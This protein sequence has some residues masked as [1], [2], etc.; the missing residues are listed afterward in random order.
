MSATHFNSVDAFLGHKTSA[1][2]SKFLTGWKE[3]GKLYAWLHCLQLP[4]GLW[5]HNFPMLVVRED[6]ETGKVERHV[7][8]Q[9]LNCWETED[10]LLKQNFRDKD[11]KVR[12]AMPTRCPLCRFIEYIWQEVYAGRLKWTDPILRYDGADDP[13]EN[14]LLHAAGIYNGFSDFGNKLT[15]EQKAEMKAASVYPSE[16]WKEN[17]K[18][19][20]SYVF[21][22]VNHDKIQDGVVV[23]IEKGT[24]GDK[25]K[26]VINDQ[27]E[28]KGVE[29]GN[30]T[31]NPYCIEFIYNEDEKK[32][33][34]K[35]AARYI[36]RFQLTEEI[37]RLIRSEPPDLSNVLQP[38]NRAEFRAQLEKHLMIDVD[39]DW[40]FDVEGDDVGE[41]PPA[42]G[43][44]DE[45]PSEPAPRAA[46]PPKQPPAQTAPATSGRRVAKPEPPKEEMG[47]PCDKCQAPMTKTQLKC[48][49]CGTEY[50]PTDDTPAAAP[51]PAQAQTTKMPT[52][53]ATSKCRH[54]RTEIPRG[55]TKCPGCQKPAV[56]F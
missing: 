49:G 36:E 52:A 48:G 38:F 41:F 40:I 45:R 3:K 16:A 20:A 6:K 9:S 30:P 15:D 14:R 34:K 11:T 50:E 10:V 25:V 37:E 4:I 53:P 12:E 5:R 22:L 46:P 24:L 2:G 43:G 21:T 1:S 28:S 26:G 39:L 35:Y 17:C 7:W 13:K 42:D 19:S 23:T 27:L 33:D 55:A 32:P 44:D 18:A 8:G 47:D 56:G 31:T 51:P 29:G 54:C